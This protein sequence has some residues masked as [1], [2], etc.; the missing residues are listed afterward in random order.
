MQSARARV[1][2]QVAS[3]ATGFEYSRKGAMTANRPCNC[4]AGQN[5]AHSPGAI[6]DDHRSRIMWTILLRPF[7]PVMTTRIVPAFK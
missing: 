3:T 2:L 6:L 5:D 4:L 7:R 1:A